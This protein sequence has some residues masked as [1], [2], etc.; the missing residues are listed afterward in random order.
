M[1]GDY[2]GI[3]TLRSSITPSA[4]LRAMPAA[5]A[6]INRNARGQCLKLRC[7]ATVTA[8]LDG[9]GHFSCR[10]KQQPSGIPPFA[11]PRREISSPLRS[12]ERLK[13][14]RL[15]RYDEE[16]VARSSMP[17]DY[18]VVLIIL[19][20]NYTWRAADIRRARHQMPNR[21]SETASRQR[22]K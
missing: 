13:Q 2:H 12:S 21:Q 20:K 5:S 3:V 10:G 19:N 15:R 8:V 17:F 18:S 1:S 16:R 14:N 11:S 6:A 4:I 22:M 7:Q 9:R